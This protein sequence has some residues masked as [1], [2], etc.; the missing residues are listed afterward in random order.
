[1]SEVFMIYVKLALFTDLFPP[2]YSWKATDAW[3]PSCQG[4]TVL[5]TIRLVN[6]LGRIKTVLK[7]GIIF[8]GYLHHNLLSNCCWQLT[9][10]FHRMGK[11]VS[12]LRFIQLRWQLWTVMTWVLLHLLIQWELRARQAQ[13][14]HRHLTSCQERTV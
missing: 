2:F 10:M 6:S 4:T 12:M 1:V 3:N 5:V 8:F 13:I 7:K 14:W 9:D 11:H